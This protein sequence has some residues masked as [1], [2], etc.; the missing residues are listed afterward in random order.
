[1]RQDA[2]ES[3]ENALA[4][5]ELLNVDKERLEYILI[6]TGITREKIDKQ[7]KGDK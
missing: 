6:G 5:V 4:E 1:M 2:E 3:R 7:M